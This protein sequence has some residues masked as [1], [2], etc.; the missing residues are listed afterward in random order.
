MPNDMKRILAKYSKPSA[1]ETAILNVIWEHEPCSVKAIHDVLSRTR[2]VGYTTTLKQVQRLHEKGLLTR[3]PGEGKSYDYSAT[4][5]EGETKSALLEGFVANTFG[6]SMSDMVM[7]ALG[8]DKTS[9]AE[10]DAIR[11]FIDQLD[12]D[13]A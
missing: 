11:A 13:K 7:H 2:S 4:V 9:E 1:A 3:Q 10:I 8:N 12:R 5:S 6:N